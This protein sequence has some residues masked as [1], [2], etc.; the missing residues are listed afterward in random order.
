M[1]QAMVQTPRKRVFIVDDHPLVRCGLAKLIENV[2]GAEV[3]GEAESAME[4]MKLI[5][6]DPPDLILVDISLK[7][8]SGLEFIK[9][10]RSEFEDKIKM[11]V[12]SMHHE[13]T[14]ADRV[15]HAGAVGYVCK[16]QADETIAVALDTV[17]NGGV[18]LSESLR[19]YFVKQAVNRE[20]DRQTASID[21]LSDR[22]LE[23]FEWIGRGLTA[24]RIAEKLCLSPKTV[25]TYRQH[26]KRKLDLQDNSELATRATEWLIGNER[27]TE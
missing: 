19:D 1:S 4:A 18:Y 8:I 14:F 13:D 24:K 20:P 26:I 11:L 27:S 5:R 15:I 21:A 9:Q 6:D 7:D 3:V 12:V 2:E 10:V 23:V 16:D 25:E 22:E 17:F